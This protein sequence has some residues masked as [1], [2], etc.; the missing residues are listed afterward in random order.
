V[1]VGVG[2]DF[3]FTQLAMGAGFA[4]RAPGSLCLLSFVSSCFLCSCF[5]LRQAI[6]GGKASKSEELKRAILKMETALLGSYDK[7]VAARAAYRALYERLDRLFRR[8]ERAG[9]APPP[10]PERADKEDSNVGA[11]PTKS[12]VSPVTPVVHHCGTRRQERIYV[13][14]GRATFA[15]PVQGGRPVLPPSPPPPSPPP[16]APRSQ[17]VLSAVVLF[18]CWLVCCRGA[19]C[20]PVYSM[21]G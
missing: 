15:A 9:V 13:V 18:V 1:P 19:C 3:D 16:S 8:A 6:G 17:L 21:R 4:G 12:R 14:S 10:L 5:S 7:V 11:G 2:L 20:V